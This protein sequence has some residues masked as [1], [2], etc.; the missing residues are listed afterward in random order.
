MK[1]V[2]EDDTLGSTKLEDDTIPRTGGGTVSPPK[3]PTK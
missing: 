3:E 2:D 1:N